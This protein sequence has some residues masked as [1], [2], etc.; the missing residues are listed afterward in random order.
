VPGTVRS[1]TPLDLYRLSP[2]EVSSASTK[3][4][5]AAAGACRLIAGRIAA[6][7]PRLVE[8]V[9]SLDE[10]QNNLEQQSRE[11]SRTH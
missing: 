1:F 9:C 7:L 6:A 10:E 8:L 2:N 4:V 11:A 3:S 5:S